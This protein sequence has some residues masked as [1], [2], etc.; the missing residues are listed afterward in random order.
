MPIRR[1][2]NLTAV[3]PVLLLALLAGGQHARGE[4]VVE[5]YPDG[6]KKAVYTTNA[7]GQKQG[8]YEEYYPDGKSKLK[9]N[10]KEDKLQGAYR[11]FHPS[12]KAAIK[13]TYRDGELYGSYVEHT[14][15]GPIRLSVGYKAGQKHGAYQEYVDR[16]L[17]RDELWIEG[18][19]ALPKSQA[20]IAREL[21][22]I[23][24]LPLKTEGE[25][26]AAA[27]RFQQAARDPAAHRDREMAL[28]H[29][30]AY[31]YLCDVPHEDLALDLQYI[32]HTEGAC[33]I[34]NRVGEMTHS[35]KNPDLP[36]DEYKFAYTGCAKSNLFSSSSMVGSVRA[37]MDDSDPKN[38][39]RVGHRRWCLNPRMLR[40]GFAGRGGYSAMWS[41]DNS[42]KEVP[43]YEYVAFPPRGLLPTTFFRSHYA[44]SVSLNPKKYATPS[45]ET[46]KVTVTP[47]RLNPARASLELAPTPLSVEYFNVDLGGF[48]IPNCIIFRPTGVQVQP[49]A[50][51]T[52]SMTGLKDTSGEDVTLE[53]V[54]AFF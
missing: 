1:S 13:T 11:S 7:A 21:A 53:Y 54:V 41:F 16:Q 12:G 30:M 34:L 22:R 9:A 42:R 17:V 8:A 27:E 25:I 14:E 5:N 45:A 3:A 23:E 33:D 35:P 47:A 2:P 36:E 48:G 37:Y 24:K 43:D 29:L 44:W 51:Y 18:Q 38:I 40:T 15:A 28:R 26:P 6:A 10:Y 19:L 20:Q 52:V 39:D 32:T 46:V 4:Q 31:R 50:A 49:G